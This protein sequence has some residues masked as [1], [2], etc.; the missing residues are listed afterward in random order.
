MTTKLKQFINYMREEIQ[1]DAEAY[2]EIC[3]LAE[4]DNQDYVKE[5]EQRYEMSLSE[6]GSNEEIHALAQQFFV[7]Y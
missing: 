5:I 7:N 1:D 4:E 6:F 2:D 3:A